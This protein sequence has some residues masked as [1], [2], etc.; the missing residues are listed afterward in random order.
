MWFRHT[1]SCSFS[2]V[3]MTL[4]SLLTAVVWVKSRESVGTA[5]KE[6]ADRPTRRYKVRDDAP[7]RAAPMDLSPGVTRGEAPLMRAEED[8]ANLG[9]SPKIF[10]YDEELYRSP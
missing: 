10:R 9:E 4:N 3:L 7:L 2:L 8:A 6:V 1:C 5:E